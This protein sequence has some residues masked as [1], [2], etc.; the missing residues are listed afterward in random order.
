MMGE[1]MRKLFRILTVPLVAVLVACG[2]GGGILA[3]LAVVVAQAVL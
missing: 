1:K 2:G 3:L